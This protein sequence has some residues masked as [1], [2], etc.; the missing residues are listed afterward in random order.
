[1][2]ELL[3]VVSIIGLL[4]SVVLASIT[5]ARAKARDS[6]RISD[7]REMQKALELYR[8]EHGDYPR[9]NEWWYCSCGVGDCVNK[10]GDVLQPLVDDGFIPKLPTDPRNGEQ[11]GDGYLC[12]EYLAKDNTDTS[13]WSCGGETR[14]DY[15]YVL[16]FT[17]ETGGFNFPEVTNSDDRFTSCIHGG[18][19]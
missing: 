4:S 1:M 2:I 5:S 14:T 11:T 6:Q 19:K 17:L 10:W 16:H 12:Y 13:S 3:V 8:L 9:G 18:L 15:E 7:M